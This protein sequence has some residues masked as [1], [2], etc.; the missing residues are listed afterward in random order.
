VDTNYAMLVDELEITIDHDIKKG[1]KPLC[2]VAALGTTGSTAIDPIEKIGQI[3]GKYKIW[4]HIDAT[5]TKTI[6]VHRLC[7]R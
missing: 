2:I 7:Q 4:F 1:R 5:F 3:S 6:I